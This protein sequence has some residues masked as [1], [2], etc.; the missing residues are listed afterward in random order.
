VNIPHKLTVE[1]RDGTLS[2]IDPRRTIDLGFCIT[3]HKAQG[4]EWPH[5]IYMLNA[6]T[7]FIQSRHNFYT[8]ISRAS[9]SATLITDQR[10][11]QNS[12]FQT[13]SAIERQQ[14]R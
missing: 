3:T 13:M 11:L 12:V 8:A 5:V 9:K 14:S 2:Q 1:K 6:S 4:S 7:L 10:S